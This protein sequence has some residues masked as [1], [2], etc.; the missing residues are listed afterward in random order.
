MHR[1]K[2]SSLEPVSALKM[3]QTNVQMEDTTQINTVQSKK[4]SA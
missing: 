2:E 1:S 4:S 3:A